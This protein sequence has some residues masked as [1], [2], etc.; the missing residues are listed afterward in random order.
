VGNM[1]GNEAVGRELLLLY[2]HKL[3]DT[4]GVDDRIT[5]LI[6]N[7][8]I[9]IMPS[10]N[11]D[12]FENS[13]EG[14]GY[15]IT[16]RANANNVDLNRDFP[17]QFHRSSSYTTRQPGKH[18][19]HALM[20]RSSLN[21]HDPIFSEVEAVMKWSTDIPFVLSA[22]LHGGSLVANYPYDSNLQGKT[23]NSPTPGTL[24]DNTSLPH[25]DEPV[26]VA[27]LYR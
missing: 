25:S 19:E 18:I 4:Y 26:T 12:G 3:L 10:M 17:D 14:D 20:I 2:I 21:F 5:N 1:H 9:H 6:N 23:S 8:R 13:L 7:T 15:S 16:G 27:M 11:P 24:T 22:N